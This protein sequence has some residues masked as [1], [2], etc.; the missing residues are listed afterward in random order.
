MKNIFIIEESITKT[1]KVKFIINDGSSLNRIKDIDFSRKNIR[2]NSICPGYVKTPLISKYLDR[3]SKQRKESLIKSYL[4]GRV[5]K[6][7]DISNGKIN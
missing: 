1:Q 5:G 7:E 4:L 6:P 3:L 2:V